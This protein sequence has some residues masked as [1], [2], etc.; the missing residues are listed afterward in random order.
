MQTTLLVL[1]LLLFMY[2]I[3]PLSTLGHELGHALAM[4][5]LH[6]HG[7]P[8]IICLGCKMVFDQETRKYHRPASSWIMR[9]PR[10]VLIVA[11]RIQATFFGLTYGQEKLSPRQRFGM[12]LAGP[13]TSLA[14]T[15]VW[16]ASAWVILHTASQSHPH[17]N[18]LQLQ[19]AQAVYLLCGVSASYNG[20]F[21]L[22]A[23]L[24]IPNQK[25]KTLS[26]KTALSASGS[27][28][29]QLL[30][31]WREHRRLPSNTRG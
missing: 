12:I 15:L 2:G 16:G 23:I 4:I 6:H 30:C 25:R 7:K 21:F 13:L 11:P 18:A 10:L 17:L 8:V 26:P 31:L 22:L 5:K 20:L 29:Y 27:D 28:G 3:M 24:P 14:L 1:C 19:I 9:W